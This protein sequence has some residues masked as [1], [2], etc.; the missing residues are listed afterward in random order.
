[1]KLFGKRADFEAFQQVMIEAY[2]RHPIR[3]LSYCVLPNHWHFLVWPAKDGQLS[4]FFRW[5]AHAHAMRWRVS[6]GTVGGGPVYQGRFKC[7]PVERDEH[8]L[9]AVRHIERSPLAA[10]LV[11]RAELWRWSSLWARKNEDDALRTLLSPWPIKC[12]ANWTARV[13]APLSGNALQQMQVCIARSR[14]F[15]ADNWVKRTVR[16]LGLEHTVRPEG[17]PRRVGRREPRADQ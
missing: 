16:A 2:E 10:G 12:P 15:G 6:R 4:G 7:F 14:P 13:N 3:I 1:M 11:E 9:T 5:L 8:L 17:R